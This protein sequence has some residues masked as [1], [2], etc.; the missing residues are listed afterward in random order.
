MN[1]LVTWLLLYPLSVELR[2]LMM[3][4]QRIEWSDEVRFWNSFLHGILYLTVAVVLWK[5]PHR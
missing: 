3:Y 2:N 1:R 4:A 5:N